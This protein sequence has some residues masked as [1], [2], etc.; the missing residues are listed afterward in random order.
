M[1][2]ENL[3]D[4]TLEKL[5]NGEKDLLDLGLGDVSIS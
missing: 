5:L 2:N 3:R 4:S 1:K